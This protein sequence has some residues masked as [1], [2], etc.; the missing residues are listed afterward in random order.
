MPIGP[1]GVVAGYEA[2]SGSMS[3]T[4]GWTIHSLTTDPSA[5]WGP[6][7]R[8]RNVCTRQAGVEYACF[9]AELTSSSLAATQDLPGG[10]SR[11]SLAGDDRWLSVDHPYIARVAPEQGGSTPVLPR[12]RDGAGLGSQSRPRFRV[13]RCWHLRG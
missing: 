12:G 13:R 4:F 3:C 6:S 1:G 2:L 10:W 8:S 9:G 7:D 5:R 11:D